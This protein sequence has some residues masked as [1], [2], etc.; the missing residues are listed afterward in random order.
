[1]LAVVY[2]LR[3][4]FARLFYWLFL[5]LAASASPMAAQVPL[6]IEVV[7]VEKGL[8]QGMIFDIT[9][10]RDGF[11]WI[12]TKD[13]LNRY[14]GYQFE[15]FLPD[16]FDP[17]SI[18]AN[19]VY[20]LYEDR[21]GW[22]WC[23][24]RNGVDV[25][26][27]DL[28]R[29]FHL[30][31]FPSPIREENVSSMLEAP[32]GAVWIEIEGS[33]WRVQ[34][35]EAEVRQASKEGR[36][37]PFYRCVQTL[38]DRS[39]EGEWFLTLCK[40]NDTTFL[41]SS[42][43]G[44]YQITGIVSE[45]PKASLLALT[46]E[47]EYLV[48]V[49][50]LG[51]LT[52]MSGDALWVRRGPMGVAKKLCDF[53]NGDSWCT[54]A[55]GRLWADIGPGLYRWGATPE[56]KVLEFR[57]EIAHSSGQ[58]PVFY[59]SKLYVDR[60]DNA[61][62]GSSGY[63]LLKVPTI[64]TK[65]LSYFPLSTQYQLVE[66]PQGRLFCIRGPRVIYDD[67]R[68][69]RAVPNPWLS[70]IPAAAFVGRVLFDARG[71]CWIRLLDGALYRVD[72]HTQQVTQV[73]LP[74]LGLLVD[75]RG[76]LLAVSPRALHVYDPHT[77]RLAEYPFS[78]PLRLQHNATQEHTLLYEDSQGV[79]WITAFEGLLQATPQA[80]G[81]QFH[82][83]CNDPENR[84][85]L[86]NNFVLCVAEDPREPRR[87]LWIGTKGGGLN[88]LDRSTHHIVHYGLAQGLPDRV[89]YGILPDGDGR[90]WFSTNKGLC[91]MSWD[92]DKPIFKNFT[93]ADGLQSSEFNQSSFL[94]TRN[95]TLLFGGINGLTVFHPDSL[96][97]R[98][99]PPQTRIV[100]VWING[101][102]QLLFGHKPLSLSYSQSF[103]TFEFAALDFSNPAQ[104]QYRYQL[105]QR[106]QWSQT[107]SSTWM[108]LGARN[109]VQF[110]NLQPGNYVLRVLG[111]NDEG[112]WSL[113]PAEVHFTIR[114]PWWAAPWAYALYIGLVGLLAWVYFRFR[115]QRRLAQKEALRLRELDD[116]KSRFF[117]NITHEF[118]TPLTVILGVT[119]RLLAR[120]RGRQSA[121]RQK[122]VLI[123]RNGQ[124]LLRLVNQLLDLAKLEANTLKMNYVQGDVL[125]YLRYI[126]QSLQSLAQT[127][128]LQ[129]RM[130][131]PETE[132]VMDYDPE[133][134]M[135]IVHNLI[136][137]AVKFTPAGGQ[138]ILHVQRSP[139]NRLLIRV[140][141]TG[142]GIPPEDLPFIFDRFY[143]A[144]NL[145]KARTGGTGIGL[146]LTRELTHAMGGNIHVESTVGQGTTF[147]VQLPIANESEPANITLASNTEA[148]MLQGISAAAPTRTS[149][150]QGRAHSLLLIEDNPDV[151]EYLRLCLEGHY[152]LDVAYN[153][154]RGIEKAL[155]TIPDLILSDV[156]MPE[157]DGFEV[158]ETLKTDERTSHIP[159]VLL[160]ARA[161][162][163]SRIAGL[164]R[165]A[166]AYLAKPFHPQE[167]L[168]TLANLL[169][170]RQK[171]Q[172]RYSQIAFSPTPPEHPVV[173]A[174]GLDVEDAFV[175]KVRA[176]VLQNL[177]NPDFNVE[178]LC[179][180]IAMSQPQ[181]HRKISALTGKNATLYI[182]SVRLAKAKELLQ[183]GQSNISEVAYEVGFNDPK[184]FSR[185]FTQEFG[186]APSKR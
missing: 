143:Q 38:P 31:L 64:R 82:Y 165:G 5:L 134:L 168:E 169:E 50:S 122:L 4:M 109:S 136:S 101:E 153:G 167:L 94:K 106:G 51:Y 48:E 149:R 173:E 58:A 115:L 73:E 39:S 18:A 37:F 34:V 128:G 110:A 100:A 99:T 89:V 20:G 159:I 116:F 23:V 138:V 54:D 52:S 175:Q 40:L 108:D 146:A 142:V 22:L 70:G 43:R 158:C 160:T 133:R 156:M 32:D 114:P 42:T 161:D 177:S 84:A 44:L 11:L 79:V 78:R 72:A 144:T 104:N 164:R 71:N 120:A 10:S 185:V 145:K 184:Y 6:T 137:N 2:F 19:T 16:P 118:R 1:M 132:I 74:G 154:Q 151:V 55:K 68:F 13:G 98:N 41:A 125:V 47:V 162:V 176:I 119:E 157:K 95:G 140:S 141:D 123:Q 30:P 174:A 67:S 24:H 36:A 85:S 14:D 81:Y 88:R 15:V 29:F 60:S 65:F 130:E 3:R 111:S 86:S 75:R 28:N 57:A 62:L 46:K 53:H 112:T 129:L 183:S 186:V 83:L 107:S 180:A 77:A 7:G 131:S 102:R 76:R 170:L 172:A 181:L 25:Y 90:L 178:A 117:T 59:F 33:L 105:L 103:L 91:R 69:E 63:G 92:G 179:R 182:R 163:E 127:S 96:R 80:E 87:Y 21:R 49:D 61:W 113:T 171:L 12:A 166:D 147:T 150:A 139:E 8:S 121:D 66:D 56:G 155:E 35:S 148:R 152:D 9:Q 126:V 124:N 135:Q 97:F 26:V 27:P 93:P 17:F 45:K